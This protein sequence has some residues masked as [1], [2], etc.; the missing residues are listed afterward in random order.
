MTNVLQPVPEVCEGAAHPA[1][2]QAGL[3]LPPAGEHSHLHLL[4]PPHRG[5]LL[6]TILYSAIDQLSVN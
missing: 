5:H 6:Q 3:E 1:A 2:G 4:V